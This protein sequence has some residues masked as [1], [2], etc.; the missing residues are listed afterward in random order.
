MCS[1]EMMFQQSD[2]STC[3]CACVADIPLAEGARNVALAHAHAA[4][5]AERGRRFLLI[6]FAR[7]ADRIGASCCKWAPDGADANVNA[8]LACGA[9]EVCTVQIQTRR[10]ASCELGKQ[11]RLQGHG[12]DDGSKGVYGGCDQ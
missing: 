8:S 1:D 11:G 7:A 3:R 4:N 10:S 12:N 5:Y 9:H 2:T 6:T